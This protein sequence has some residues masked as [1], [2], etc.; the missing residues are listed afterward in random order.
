[1]QQNAYI[2]GVGMTTF[3]K[4]QDRTLKSL[5]QEA[6][7][8]ALQDAGL[9]AKELEAAY[10]GTAATAVT[11]GQVMIPGQVALRE[12]GI[13]R[14]PVINVENAC[15][16]AATAFQQ[17]CTMVTAGVYDVVLAIGSENL[18]GV[19]RRGRL[20]RFRRSFQRALRPHQSCRS[21]CR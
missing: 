17:A 3:S 10:F 6:V 13:G 12:M 18:F 7:G 14:I 4:H 9:E 20:R 8:L 16:S 15:A 2:A 1:M 5:T 21:R 11:V 19:R